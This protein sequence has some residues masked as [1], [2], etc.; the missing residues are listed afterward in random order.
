MS[1]QRSLLVAEEGKSIRVRKANVMLEAEVRMM[2]LL[3]VKVDRGHEPCNVGSLQKLEKA[4][5]RILLYKL[6]Y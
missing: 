6:C 4:R 2:Q 1:S 3:A 5:K